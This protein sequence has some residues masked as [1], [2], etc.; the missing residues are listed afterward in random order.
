MTE[1]LGSADDIDALAAKKRADALDALAKLEIEFARLRDRLFYE[2]MDDLARERW[3]ID[4][5]ETQQRSASHC[6]AGL[7]TC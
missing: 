5:G 6:A 4:A 1:G 2:K 7:S 3:Q